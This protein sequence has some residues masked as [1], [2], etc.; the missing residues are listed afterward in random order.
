MTLPSAEEFAVISVRPDIS[1]VLI[2]DDEPVDSLYSEKL[3]R[4]LTSAL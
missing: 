4:L 3:Q 1:D 2:E